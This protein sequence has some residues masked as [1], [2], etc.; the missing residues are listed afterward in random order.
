MSDLKGI[1]ILDTG[2]FPAQRFG[3][4][5]PKNHTFAWT[6]KTD[7][8]LRIWQIQV[9]MGMDI[10]GKGDFWYRLTRESDGSILSMTNWD[11]YRDPTGLHMVHMDYAPNWFDL[12]PEDGLLLSCGARRWN[13]V[14]PPVMRAHVAVTIWVTNAP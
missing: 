12:K 3:W 9:W 13:P 5:P 14:W 10:M 11:H 4:S 6:N 8:T 2:P 7:K 1:Q